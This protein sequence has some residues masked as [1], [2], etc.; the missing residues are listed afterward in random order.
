MTA[1]EPGEAE[2][3]ELRKGLKVTLWDRWEVSKGGPD[4]TLG[5][6]LGEL[7]STYKLKA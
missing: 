3:V 1:S 6:L 4:I 5:G 7:E 2:V